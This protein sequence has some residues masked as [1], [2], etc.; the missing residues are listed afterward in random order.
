MQP[1]IRGV[2]LR[3]SLFSYP[4]EI[5]GQPNRSEEGRQFV[6]AMA[7]IIDVQSVSIVETAHRYNLV[8]GEGV[9]ALAKIPSLPFFEVL[10]GAEEV[11]VVTTSVDDIVPP[12]SQRLAEMNQDIF[13]FFLY[14]PFVLSRQLNSVDAVET[15]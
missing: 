3:F 2:R 5:S 9:S 1:F 14:E 10:L 13:R 4:P 11:H 7:S 8:E 12:L 6:V 15:V